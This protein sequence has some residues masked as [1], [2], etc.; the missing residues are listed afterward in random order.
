MCQVLTLTIDE[1]TT[2]EYNY[3][4]EGSMTWKS[5]IEKLYAI[6]ILIITLAI[7]TASIPLWG[8]LTSA[9][10]TTLF[11]IASAIGGWIFFERTR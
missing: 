5:A 1:S 10:L 11:L 7:F 6:L 2:R 9:I 4:G 3:K 8:L